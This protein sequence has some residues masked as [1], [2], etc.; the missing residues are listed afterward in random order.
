MLETV[1]RNPPQKA[2]QELIDLANQRGGHDNITLQILKVKGEVPKP[3]KRLLGGKRH[4]L[5]MIIFILSLLFIVNGLSL[6]KPEWFK[7]IQTEIEGWW[8]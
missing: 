5:V 8:K 1:R 3:R 7:K 4:L 6:V 2:C